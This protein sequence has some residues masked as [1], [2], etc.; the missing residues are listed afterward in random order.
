MFE[1]SVGH[2]YYSDMAIDDIYVQKG[3]CCNMK[4][5]LNNLDKTGKRQKYP[6]TLLKGTELLCSL[7]SLLS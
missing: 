3:S 6:T 4:S 2:S 5:E 1:A 7:F